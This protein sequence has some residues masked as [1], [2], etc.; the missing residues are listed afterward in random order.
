MA[1]DDIHIKVG[2]WISDD[3]G[4]SG[5]IT[6]INLGLSRMDPAGES[7]PEVEEFEIRKEVFTWGSILFGKD[8]WA[9]F[10]QITE[11]FTGEKAEEKE[12]EREW[13]YD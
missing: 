2:D 3:K 12:K 9:Y 13:L 6:Q 8:N 7:G 1:E 10:D 11:V 5:L 4:R